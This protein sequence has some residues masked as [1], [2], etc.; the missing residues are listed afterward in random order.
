MLSDRDRDRKTL[1]G[2]RQTINEKQLRK[3]AQ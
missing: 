3:K 1:I 2:R